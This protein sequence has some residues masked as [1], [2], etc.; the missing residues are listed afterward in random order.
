MTHGFPNQF[1]IGFFQGG[2][3]ASTTETFNNQARHIAWIVSKAFERGAITVSP[4]WSRRTHTSI[5]SAR[6]RSTP[7]HSSENAH[8]DI[9]TTTDKKSQ[10]RRPAPAEDLHR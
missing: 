2:F 1:F 5:T 9:S 7:R 10:T 8:P 3:N 4:A 6:W